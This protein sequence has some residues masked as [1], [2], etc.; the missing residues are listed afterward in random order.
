MSH[1]LIRPVLPLII[2]VMGALIWQA[3]G[4]GGS[5]PTP[6]TVPTEEPSPQLE[7]ILGTHDLGVGTNRVSF[8]LLTAEGLI[9]TPEASVSSMYVG[10]GSQSDAVETATA[11]FHLWPFGTRGN[12]VTNL[13]FDKPGAW[14]L[15]VSVEDS[16]GSILTG[17][18]PLEVKDVTTAPW[19]GDEPPLV[20]SKTLEDVNTLTELTVWS[21][22]DPDLY[23]K[24]IP[25]AI[26]EE[27]PLVLVISS[28]T[29]CTTPTCG[30][31]AE[32]VRDLKNKYQDQA[33]F[34]HVDVYDNP[35]Q[36]QTDIDMGIYS[37]V[38]EAW[39]LL[40]L[41]GYLNESWVFIIDQSGRIAA[42]YEAYASLDELEQG[43]LGVF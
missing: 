9:T 17:S 2:I 26:E 39:G 14:E 18:I 23:R 24:S 11:S 35:D 41:E 37:P 40:E 34:I 5:D 15:D 28:P 3:C 16:N 20:E 29:F 12:Y 22:P 30:P 31:Q 21:T 10:D 8:L 38:V 4:G 42:R 13:S 25:D 33:N 7:A 27:I 32:T 6:T 19:I 43:L 1:R 36:I